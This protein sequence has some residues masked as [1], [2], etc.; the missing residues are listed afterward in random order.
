[1][2][3]LTLSVLIYLLSGGAVALA[4]AGFHYAVHRGL[5]PLRIAETRTPADL[6]LAF[7]EVRIATANGRTL[8]GWFL[9][10]VGAAPAPAVV[11]LH[12]WGG[13][14]ETLLPL[15]PPLQQAGFALLLVDAR[16]H[17]R[18]DQ[19]S[20]ASMPRFAEDLEHAVDWLQQQDS[21]D[22][23]RVAVLGHSVGAGAALLAASRR[24]DIAAAVSV[25]AFAHP[26]EVM[27]RLLASKH[28]PYLPFGWYILRYVQYV[29]G[30]RFD[31]I[32]PLTTIG[33]V[34]CPTLLIHG[35]EDT[36][37]PVAEAQAIYAARG[38]GPV[39]L[40]IVPGSHDDYGDIGQEAAYL[41]AFL[42]DNLG[43]ERSE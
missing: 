34:R 16:C 13:N 43:T 14:V 41:V 38:D 21:V 18:S 24:A 15:A 25:A 39:E 3:P 2:H 31:D 42:D 9:P 17:G 36:T 7:R 27:R 12:G 28:I 26:R 23:G 8:F 35:A 33:R 29:I 1:M 40:K 30:H 19:D 4:V 11:L 20:F 22:P 10:A 6:G 37:V 32:A 5:A